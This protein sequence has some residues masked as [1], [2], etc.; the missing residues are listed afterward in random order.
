MSMHVEMISIMIPEK[1]FP[2][3]Q[4]KQSKMLCNSTFG[5]EPEMLFLTKMDGPRTLAV[6]DFILF[7]YIINNMK[8]FLY[9]K[10]IFL[11]ILIV[12]TVQENYRKIIHNYD[13]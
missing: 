12:L 2:Q 9:I 3:Q 4:E 6:P 5:M 11:A 8:R 7:I 13:P 1:R 10:I